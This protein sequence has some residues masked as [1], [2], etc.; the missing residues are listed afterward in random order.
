MT[1]NPVLVLSEDQ[2]C[3]RSCSFY[4][5]LIGARENLLFEFILALVFS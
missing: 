5:M 1:R 2:E 3:M 4:E